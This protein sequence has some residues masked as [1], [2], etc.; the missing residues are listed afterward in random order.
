MLVPPQGTLDQIVLL[1]RNSVPAIE[2]SLS[3][4]A[5]RLFWILALAEFTYAGIQ[6]A[7]RKADMLE[8]L[9]SLMNQVL[10]IGFF[11][12]LLLNS[13]PWASAI[14]TSFRQA[15]SAA[16]VAAGGSANLGPSDIVGIGI[17]LAGTVADQTTMLNPAQSLGFIIVAIILLICFAL[18]ALWMIE[19]LVQSYIIISAGAL[20][21]GFGG[22]RWTKDLALKILMGAVSIGA[23]LFVL[24]LLVGLG[25][26]IMRGWLRAAAGTTLTFRDLW[27][28]LAASL[29]M[30]GLTK[31]VPDLVQSLINGTAFAGGGG[32]LGA[33]AAAG[34]AAGAAAGVAL[35][36]GSAV[37]GAAKLASEQLASQGASGGGSSA[38]RP[39]AFAAAVARNLGTA[40]VADVGARL[41][42]RAHFGNM[43]GRMA[44][45]LHSRAT[46]AR[47]ERE[48]NE[49]R[50]NGAGGASTAGANGADNGA[51][52]GTADGDA[53]ADTIGPSDTP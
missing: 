40:A 32:L 44:Q 8:W 24:Q 46:T 29:V 35:G 45:D 33:A 23:K 27:V 10:F 19:A 12:S 9:A 11:F 53:G 51:R 16:S 42:G 36:G 52:N 37:A 22:S 20:F 28:M 26:S 7:F 1:Y 17:D 30:V 3:T 13:G 47:A 39:A 6:L 50:A 41:G 2:A 15:G 21:M 14:V 48:H 38:A 4:Y 49:A 34:G 18:I 25:E 31:G 43:T 5:I